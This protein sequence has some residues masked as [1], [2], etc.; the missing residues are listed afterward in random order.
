MTRTGMKRLKKTGTH[1]IALLGILG[2]LALVLS[3][4]ENLIM[5]QTA[6]LPAG[7]KPGLSNIV[8]MFAACTMG[9]PGAAYIVVI[10]AA[11]AFITRGATAFFMSLA[12]GALSMTV[13]V[14]LLKIEGERLSLVGIGVL[15]ACAHN[16]GQLLVSLIMTG[17]GAILNYAPFLM[18]FGVLTGFVT[19]TVLKIVLPKILKIIGD[20]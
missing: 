3:F 1:K 17:T 12:G 4:T 5:P 14:L 20:R 19:G 11:F 8:T 15:S 9:F 13:T 10:K 7:A 2:A 6:F 16:A 18:I